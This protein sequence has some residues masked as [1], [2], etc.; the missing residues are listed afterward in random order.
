MKP[1]LYPYQ[2]QTFTLGSELIANVYDYE[3][4]RKGSYRLEHTEHSRIRTSQRGI[5]DSLIPYVLDFGN[6][7]LRQGYSFYV[8][9]KNHLPQ[10]MPFWLKEKLNNLVVVMGGDSNKIITCYK[11]SNAMRHIKKKLKYLLKG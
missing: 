5:D 9:A 11:S 4:G 10:Q 7:F 2:S 6:H 1:L 3:K 8:I